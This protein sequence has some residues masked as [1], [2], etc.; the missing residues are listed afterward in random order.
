MI[1]PKCGYESSGNYCSNCGTPFILDDWGD[2]DDWEEWNPLLEP[3]DVDFAKTPQEDKKN[4]YGSFYRKGAGQSDRVRAERTKRKRAQ[5]KPARPKPSPKD[6]GRAAPRADKKTQKRK[7]ARLK[8]LEGEV[9]HLRSQRDSEGS[10]L[11]RE[12]ESVRRDSVARTL[13]EAAAK[14]VTGTIVFSSRLMQLVSALLM[15]GMVL[16]MGVSFWEHGQGM[17][18]IRFLMEEANYELAVYVGFAGVSLFLGLI[19]SLWILSRKGAGGG[20]RM[21][22]YDTGRGFLPFLICFGVVFS[23]GILLPQIP[24]EAEAWR[25]T[26]NGVRAAA[27]AI[28]AYRRTLLVCC[29]LGALLSLIRKILRV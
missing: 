13:G 27:E 9:E 11:H 22:K 8:K 4:L 10:G 18:D 20:V 17:G 25:H 12:E 28:V 14:G 29:G 1:C 21:K 7:D 6:K 19:W 2:L 5:E 24:Q 23:A 3:D 26:A 15:A 16:L